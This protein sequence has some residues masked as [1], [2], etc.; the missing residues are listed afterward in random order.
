MTIDPLICHHSSNCDNFVRK[1]QQLTACPISQNLFPS[2]Y[3][4]LCAFPTCGS[5]QYSVMI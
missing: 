5:I 4:L 1:P 3:A 2:M